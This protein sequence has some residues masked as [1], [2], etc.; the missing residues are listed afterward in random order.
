M[1]SSQQV[2]DHCLSRGGTQQRLAAAASSSRDPGAKPST[3]SVLAD[4]LLNLF[5]WGLISAS[6]VQWLAAGAVDDG[7]H[8]GEVEKLAS[9]GTNGQYAG[10]CRRDLFR[11]F[12]SG[13]LLPKPLEVDCHTYS[14][15]LEIEQSKLNLIVPSELVDCL[16]NNYPAAFGSLFGTAP[17]GFWDQ[18]NPADPKLVL[19]EQSLGMLENWKDVAIPYILHGDGARFTDK[20]SNSLLTVSFR[21]LLVDSFENAIL[22]V[23]SLPK[24]TRVPKDSGVEDAGKTLWRYTTHFFQAL[25][26]GKHPGLDPDGQPWGTDAQACLAGKPI[27]QGRLIFVCWIITGDL[28]FL[29]NE[30]QMPHFNSGKPCWLCGAC[31]QEGSPDM[32]TDL[33]TNA[34][35][36]ATL[37]QPGEG[38]FSPCSEHP[39]MSIPGVSRFSVPGDLMHTGDLGV[40]GYFL[41][42]ILAE[43]LVDGPFTG[44]QAAQLK[45]IW[46]LVQDKYQELGVTNRLTNLTKEMFLRQGDFPVLKAKAAESRALL[47]V[48]ESVCEDL[49]D[50]SDRDQ[51]RLRAL[52]SLAEMYRIF[53]AGPLVIPQHDADR[54]LQCLEYFW[55]HYSWLLK[56][57][58]SQGFRLYG[59]YFKFHALWHIVDHSRFINPKRV[60]CY[61]FEDFMHV[62]VTAAKA[63][64]A[65]SPMK[66][67]GN[68]VL[69]NWLLVFHLFLR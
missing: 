24:S 3:Q 56:R 39:I 27:C 28:E 20:N 40:L 22:P 16:Y 66:I 9:L 57:A 6:T 67:I 36:K 12:G 7:L 18:I 15:G 11:R 10:N 34:H 19:L 65:G 30:L 60:W 53:M 43:L 45:V 50:G 13:M 4:R 31:R 54:A 61:E 8:V 2:L 38:G 37:W 59:L 68:K 14:K 44:P 21:S 1:I 33:S 41:G 26:A 63:C 25:F 29:G 17:R 69:E 52:R 51:H 47:F 48:L 32:I 46:R 55:G 23:F 62:V 64:I 35:W 58:L 42:S 49:D 5:G